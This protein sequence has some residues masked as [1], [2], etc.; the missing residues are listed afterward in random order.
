MDIRKVLIEQVY[1]LTVGT[2]KQASTRREGKK[3]GKRVYWI[4][5]RFEYRYSL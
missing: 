4:G 5:R 3:F 1:S 2:G